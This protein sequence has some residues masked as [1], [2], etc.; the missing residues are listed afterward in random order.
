[1]QVARLLGARV[2]AVTS[3]Q[4]KEA[5]LRRYGADEVVVSAGE[6]HKQNGATAQ[7]A[8]DLVGAPTFNSSLR[9]LAMGGRLVLVGNVTT[10]RVDVNPGYCILRELSVHGSSGATRAE[11]SQV[12]EWAA[13]GKLRPV[14]DERLPLSQAAKAQERLMKREV[15]GRQILVP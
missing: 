14:V 8:L 6:F 11:L 7:V 1:M 5:A 2:L 13:E 9:S 4:K 15:V 3:N 10:S 12:L